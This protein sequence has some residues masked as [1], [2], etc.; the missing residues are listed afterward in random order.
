M[1]LSNKFYLLLQLALFLTTVYSKKQPQGKLLQIVEIFRHGARYRID[2]SSYSDNNQINYG[3]LTAHGQ[4]MHFLLGKT[5]YDKYSIT[6]NIPK[7]YNHTFIYVKST[8]YDRTIM[9]A[10]SQL[11]GI[12]P[13]QYGL[14]ISNVSDQFLMPP[15]QNVSKINET[16]FALEGGFQPIP[17]HV[18]DLKDEKQLLGYMDSCYKASMWENENHKS[19][20]WVRIEKEYQDLLDAL[21]EDEYFGLKNDAN[22]YDI[23]NL[24]DTLISEKWFGNVEKNKEISEH[25]DGFLLS[26]EQLVLPE[27]FSKMWVQM[28]LLYTTVLHLSLYK[29]PQQKKTSVTP[30]FTELLNY[31][32]NYINNQQYYKWIMLSAH[33][34]TIAMIS[35][36]MNFTSWEC[37][38]QVKLQQNVSK[39]CIYTYPGFSSNII[40]ELYQDKN[41]EHFIKVLYNGTEQSICG[42][43]KKYCYLK[44]FSQALKYSTVNDYDLECGNQMNDNQIFGTTQ[45]KQQIME[46]E[47]QALF[48]YLVTV[49]SI[50]LIISIIFNYL[51]RRKILIL[52]QNLQQRADYSTI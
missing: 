10:A 23:S 26:Q 16:V 38:E 20:E 4:R 34:T 19:E 40:F 44:E 11:A 24:V 41:N 31:F 46:S 7:T 28:N 52:R 49:L 9:S 47:N 13:L 17:I 21:I 43:S 51:Q 29:T 5:L 2:N 1:M 6:L 35:Q 36:G 14:K 27:N 39:N 25:V 12:F 48:T 18:R 3:Q 15:F 50:L 42:S 33:D 22:L 8:N 45:E 37:L 30:F 32:N